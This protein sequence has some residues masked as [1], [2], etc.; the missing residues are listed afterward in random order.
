MTIF[1]GDITYQT[2]RYPIFLVYICG[3]SLESFQSNYLR[4][5]LRGRKQSPS[6]ARVKTG[7]L[8]EKFLFNP[9]FNRGD[10]LKEIVV[11]ER[12]QYIIFEKIFE[13]TLFS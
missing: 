3:L 6:T 2:W 8:I 9:C 7:V 12:I 4:S 5:I 1:F 13:V 11:I 10:T